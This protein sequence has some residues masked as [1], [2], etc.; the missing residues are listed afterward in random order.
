MSID[1][2]GSVRDGSEPHG[3]TIDKRR[4]WP[5]LIGIV[6]VIVAVATVLIIQR[7]TGTASP[8]ETAGATLDV[9]YLDSN[10]AEK[11]II[12][13]IAQHIAPDYNVKVGAVGLGDSTQINQAISDGRYAGTIFQHRHWLQQVL[14]ANPGF[15]EEAATGP[16]FHWVFGIGPTSTRR[17]RKSL[18]MQRFRCSPTRPTTPRAS[19]TWRRPD[20]S[21]CGPT[22]TSPR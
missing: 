17:H 5:W 8:N 20:S 2:S 11:R 19:G 6:V 22:R 4:K 14:D 13:Y 21:R 12:E 3:F 7:N 1:E 10:P 15:K 9:V 18:T 16:F